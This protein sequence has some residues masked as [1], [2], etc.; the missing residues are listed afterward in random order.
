M[1][2]P[3]QP[4]IEILDEEYEFTLGE[5]A[6]ACEASAEQLLGLIEEGVIEPSGREPAQ[7]RFQAISVQRVQCARRLQRDLGLNRAGVAMV[8]DLLDE[9][10][11]L[12][13]QL[14]LPR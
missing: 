1:N 9:I 14:S 5:L 4:K 8:L 6:R 3:G 12:R 10:R 11:Q 2:I 13:R 7:W